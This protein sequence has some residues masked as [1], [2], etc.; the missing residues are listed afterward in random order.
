MTTEGREKRP[1]TAA[2][3]RD[4]RMVM[5]LKRIENYSFSN[6]ETVPDKLVF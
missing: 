6:A 2:A 3:R 4:L 5:L 1:A